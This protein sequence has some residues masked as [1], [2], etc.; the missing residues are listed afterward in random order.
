M[1]TA[2]DYS[3]LGID[4][5]P[6]VNRLPNHID[7]ATKSLRSHR[8]PDGCADISADLTSDQTLSTVHGNGAHC[9]L[10]CKAHHR[11]FHITL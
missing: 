8:D 10:T 2:S 6:L 7:D 3:R 9:V 11:L 4:W 1:H 5:P